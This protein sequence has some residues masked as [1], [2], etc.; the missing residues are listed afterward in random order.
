MGEVTA[1]GNKVLLELAGVPLFI[2][3]LRTLL[4]CPEIDEIC[5]IH[6]PGDEPS[7]RLCLE[8]LGLIPSVRLQSGGKERFESVYCGLASLA[9]THPEIVLIHDSARP[10]PSKRMIRETIE[11][12]RRFGAATV[13]VPLS[14]T[15]KRGAEG[16]LAETLPR[17]NLFRIQTP[18]TFRFDWIWE[19]HQRL[20][21]HPDPGV[22]DDCVILEREG[23]RIAP[24]Q[25]DE[26][27][28]K[29]T[30]PFDLELARMILATGRELRDE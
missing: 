22:T 21:D 14:D 12:A 3:P 25:G 4:G 13:A 6:R 8:S 11:K 10:F 24:V 17:E 15:L 1:G 9:E 27:N 2:H 23:R 7:V 18:Q 26:F 16:Y 20:Q 28:I 19:A 29:V 5:L 30:T